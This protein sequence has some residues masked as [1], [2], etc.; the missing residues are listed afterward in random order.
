MSGSVADQSPN[1]ALRVRD[2]ER[3]AVEQNRLIMAL[4]GIVNRLAHR[5]IST[6]TGEPVRASRTAPVDEI[7]AAVAHV[8]GVSH[9]D[10]CGD[11]KAR[12]YVDARREVARLARAQGFSLPLIGEAMGGRDHTTVRNLLGCPKVRR[13]PAATALQA[14]DEV[15]IEV[16]PVEPAVATPA[17][18][19]LPPAPAEP[20][21]PPDVPKPPVA[22]AVP[23]P[24]PRP[25]MPPQFPLGDIGRIL[26]AARVDPLAR[27]ALY[28]FR[29]EHRDDL[30]SLTRDTGL[31]VD[32]IVAAVIASGRARPDLARLAALADDLMGVGGG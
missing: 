11:N 20:G 23:P 7:I 25:S 32:Q 10:I 4:S 22:V 15:V 19:V 12:R 5:H 18:E 16:P 27:G 28:W 13:K 8:H 14:R 30:N 17:P 29:G 31:T 26:V 21:P 3:R 24:S 6:A 9:G 1:L 2:L